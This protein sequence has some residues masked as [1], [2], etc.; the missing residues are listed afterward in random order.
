MRIITTFD[1][2]LY[3]ASGKRLLE[4]VARHLP[5]AKI[6]VYEELTCERVGM[7]SVRVNQIPEFVQVFASHRDV[8]P[9]E[10][11]G[12]AERLEGYNRRWFGW[13]RKIVSQYDAITRNAYDGYTVFLDTDVRVIAPFSDEDIRAQLPKAVGVF[14]GLRDSIESGVI[15]YD[16]RAPL[17]R[18]FVERFM[19]L[20]L[21]GQFRALPRWDDSF[22]MA[23]CMAQ[24]PEAV[25]DFAAG[26]A[27]V[28]HT[29]SNGHTTGGQ[30]LPATVWD[31]YLEHD[32]GI[33]W[34]GGVVPQV[35]SVRSTTRRG[36]F[37]K[38][39]GGLW[40]KAS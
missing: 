16:G 3:A 31:H 18:P 32:K 5:G 12:S 38:W 19:D 26:I 34:R 10:M 35:H 1:D 33:H 24:M 14:M 40:R 7:P 11:G 36:L 28:E 6:L 39:L 9:R 25:H 20:F 15:F 27:P 23:H 22:T 2:G 17:A 21:S 13:F 29:N 37:G 30:V 8:I 4:S